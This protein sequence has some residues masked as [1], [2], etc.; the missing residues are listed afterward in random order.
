MPPPL[1]RVAAA[2]AVASRRCHSRRRPRRSVD[3][4]R[5]HDPVG[6]L[7]KHLSVHCCRGGCS[8]WHSCASL[9]CGRGWG[10]AADSLEPPLIILTA[11]IEAHHAAPQHLDSDGRQSLQ[12]TSCSS[13]LPT[14][15]LRLLAFDIAH[16]GIAEPRLDRRILTRC[17]PSF[18]QSSPIVYPIEF[19]EF[20]VG[21]RHQLQPAVVVGVDAQ[22]AARPSQRRQGRTLG[23]AAKMVAAAVVAAEAAVAEA[24]VVAEEGAAAVGAQA[25][26]CN[27]SLISTEPRHRDGKLRRWA[28]SIAR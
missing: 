20:A 14:H 9:A 17:A 27:R 5:A 7:D 25:S 26:T 4:Q 3:L 6:V 18:H 12:A 19:L 15:T 2:V 8:S 21:M 16:A 23:A 10:Q 11:G 22:L 13:S 28:S 1:L 24:G